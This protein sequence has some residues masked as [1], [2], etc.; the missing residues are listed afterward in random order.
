MAFGASWAILSGIVP[1]SYFDTDFPEHVEAVRLWLAGTAAL[2]A[3]FLFHVLTAAVA[4]LGA[5][6]ETAAIAVLATSIGATAVIVDSLYL[7]SAAHPRA[8]AGARALCL[9]VACAATAIYAHGF[10]T[11]YIGQSSPT[12]WHNPTAMLLKPFA[13]ASAL[14]I[15]RIVFGTAR[16]STY[17]VAALTL[18]LG[19]VAKPAFVLVF[20][21]V[22][23]VLAAVV[24]LPGLRSRLPESFAPTARP[25]AFA[26]LLLAGLAAIALWVQA[27]YILPV[28]PGIELR[29]FLVWS[30][31]T[32]S[33][34]FSLLLVLAFPI[35]A[36]VLDVRNRV[37]LTGLALAWAYVVV[38]ALL[39]ALLAEKGLM[40]T[41]GNLGWSFQV[42]LSVLYAFSVRS[43][44]AHWA[45]GRRGW[46]FTTATTLLALH[47]ASGA[48]YLYQILVLRTY[49]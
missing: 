46:E 42:A 44:F 22:A 20:I 35:A 12:I 8:P 36:T 4:M 13:L 3:H 26:L 48:Y 25:A 16:R 1:D 30:P 37:P 11:V 29:P 38:G 18:V 45:L 41:H 34:P 7:A 14:C 9:L 24:A 31:L 32:P 27:R 28:R 5:P 40:R 39:Y 33:I 49:D 21:P 6:L 43:H 17:I 47:A 15:E 10:N 19:L 23:L 2:P